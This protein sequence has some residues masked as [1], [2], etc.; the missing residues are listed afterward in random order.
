MRKRSLIVIVSGLLLIGISSAWAKRIPGVP[1]GWK[2]IPPIHV[3]SGVKGKGA[4]YITGH[5]YTPSQVKTAYAI[6][7]TATVGK[8]VTIA[9]VD[10]YGSSTIQ[11][12]L[13]AF[14]SAYGLPSTTLKI[15]YPGGKPTTSN[16]DWALETSLD[17]EWVHA[18]A[19]GAQIALVI[20][21]TNSGDDLYS[22]VRY[23]ATTLGAQVVSMSW[24]GKEWSAETQV[25]SY[26]QHPGTVFVA[27]SG[28]SGSGV[29]YPAASPF[30]IAVGGTNL[31]L[32]PDGKR[33][34]PEVAWEESG[35]GISKYE[36]APVYQTTFGVPGNGYRGVPDVAMIASPATGVMVYDSNYNPG[37]NWW[38]VG[39]TSLSAPCFAAIIASADK[40]RITPIT[41]GHEILYSLAGTQAAFNPDKYYRDITQGY[42]GDFAAEKGYDFVTGLGSA[43]ASRLVPALRAATD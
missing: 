7:Q 30:V 40:G 39:G 25:D 21:K 15:Y 11:S 16:A 34:W 24:G 29:N 38:I 17:V 23:A 18:L 3:I 20:A 32:K 9:I 10:A 1:K 12:D 4:T 37:T 36:T 26:F 5:G 33:L 22:A 6:G 19:P 2:A 31:Y 27:S 41:D 13:A 35:G 28:D 14:N 43:K 8:G 42:N